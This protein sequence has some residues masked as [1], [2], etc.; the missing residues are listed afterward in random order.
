MPRV[1]EFFGIAIYMY[2]MVMLRRTFTR[3]MPETKPRLR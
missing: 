3:S 2:Y 1:S